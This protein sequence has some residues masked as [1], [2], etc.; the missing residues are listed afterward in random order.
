MAK[1]KLCWWLI[2]VNKAKMKISLAQTDKKLLLT[3]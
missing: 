3:T 1:L 2:I